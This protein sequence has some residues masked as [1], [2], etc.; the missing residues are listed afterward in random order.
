MLSYIWKTDHE[1]WLKNSQKYVLDIDPK[2]S[3]SRNMN[4]INKN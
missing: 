1:I 4:K 2:D 3:D